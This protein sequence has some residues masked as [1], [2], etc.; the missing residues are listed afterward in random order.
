MHV[1]ILQVENN[2]HNMYQYVTV[3]LSLAYVQSLA[4]RNR[5][6]LSAHQEVNDGG[7]CETRYSEDGETL[8]H[9]PGGIVKDGALGIDGESAEDTLDQGFV[10]LSSDDLEISAAV[11]ALASTLVFS[12]DGVYWEIHGFYGI[13]KTAPVHVSYFL[14]TRDGETVVTK[15]QRVRIVADSDST[16]PRDWDNVGRMICWHN[17]YDLGDKH[18]YHDPVDFQRELAC[19]AV[20]GLEERVSRLENEGWDRRFD[21]A[22]D[23]G[24]DNP[25]EYVD[26]VVDAKIAELV[27]NAV[28]NNYVILPLYLYDHSGITMST[29]P[30][31]CEWDSGQVGWI[32]CDKETTERDFNGDRGLAEKCLIAEVATYDQYLTGDVYGFIVEERDDDD[33][34]GW[35]ELD[36]CWGFFGSDVHENGMAGHLGSDEL[37]NLAASAE[38]EYP[39]Y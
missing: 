9:R 38:I 1:A 29:C 7:R 21:K 12:R 28:D 27:S 3:G 2:N 8:W 37:I 31:A 13:E 33:D 19:E 14:A 30:F 17:R 4:E 11:R 22:V 36:S 23:D 15:E 34:E 25:R 39:S 5:V 26:S 18:D 10:V 24:I 16:N 32:I 20:D 6:F 35:E